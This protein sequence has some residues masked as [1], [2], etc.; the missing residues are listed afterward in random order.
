MVP[1]VVP[2]IWL[3]YALSRFRLLFSNINLTLSKTN[4]LGNL[5]CKDLENLSSQYSKAS[6]PYS[7]GIFEY[8]P[9]TS[10]SVKIVSHLF[11]LEHFARKSRLSLI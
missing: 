9:T 5:R 10:N 2:L 8:S 4:F 3:K 7:W 11:S 6:R 1:I